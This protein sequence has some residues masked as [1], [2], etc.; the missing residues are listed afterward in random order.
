VTTA[1]ATHSRY[2]DHYLPGYQHPEFPGRI[3]AV[4]HKM[5]A[6]G[7]PDRLHALTATPAKR[8][9]IE[10]V[11]SAEHVSLLEWIAGQQKTV[12][13]DSDTYA[14]PA[15]YEIARLSAGGVLQVVDA[16]LDGTADNGLAAVRPPGHHATPERAMGFCLLNNIAIAARHAQQHPTAKIGRVLIV[17]YDV[18]HGNGTQDAFYDDPSVLFISV[19][20]APFYPGTGALHERGSAAGRG[21]TINIPLS[22]NHGDASYRT[23][24]EQIVWPAARRYKPDLMLISAGFDAH[25]H[26]PLAYMQLSMQGYVQLTRELLRMADE[27]CDGRIVFVMEGGYD[28]P[29]LSSGMCNVAHVLLGEDVVHDP[30]GAAKGR[31]NDDVA[32]LVAQVQQMHDLAR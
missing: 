1:Y 27:L 23:I 12:M 20:Q 14:L 15:S 31:Q 22:A 18:H 7:L 28:L 25:W 5:T 24:F 13:I 10:R 8:E 32:Q 11:H 21:T 9:A 26:D 3:E 16:V 19:H 6:A 2:T 30:Y 4:W 17:D 29:A